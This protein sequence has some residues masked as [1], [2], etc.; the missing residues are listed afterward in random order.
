MVK[1]ALHNVAPNPD[2]VLRQYVK[3][4]LDEELTSAVFG[5]RCRR[6]PRRF[7]SVRSR[8]VWARAPLKARSAKVALKPSKSKQER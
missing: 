6:S 7:L 2:L 4:I 5:R 3:A 8:L 1:R